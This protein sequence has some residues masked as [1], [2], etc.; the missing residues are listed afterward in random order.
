M[1]A[2]EA[3]KLNVGDWVEA[4]FSGRGVIKR[5]QIV[6]IAWPTFTLRTRDIK[7]KDMVRTRRYENLGKR[8]EADGIKLVQGPFWLVWPADNP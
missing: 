6:S 8:C 1:T 4:T 2:G 3:R 7:G 5:C